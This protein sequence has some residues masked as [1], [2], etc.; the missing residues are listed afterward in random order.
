MNRQGA[1]AEGFIQPWVAVTPLPKG[2]SGRFSQSPFDGFGLGAGTKEPVAAWE[3]LK[4]RTGDPLRRALH[5]QG[6]GGVPALKA[7]AASK[8]YLNEKLPP[9]WNKLFVDTM[10]IVRLPPPTP[11]WSDIEPM[12]SQ[13]YQQIQRG[14]VT[15]AAALHDLVPRVN[16][17]LQAS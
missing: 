14:E 16:A 1:S 8:E 2:S 10:N 7:T 4:F 12:V 11:K 13:V 5:A 17:L 15:P 9:E 3:V 6:Q